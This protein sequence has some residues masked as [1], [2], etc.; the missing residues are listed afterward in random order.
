[1]ARVHLFTSDPTHGEF[2]PLLACLDMKETRVL[3]SD[4]ID[5]L[6]VVG[7][8]IGSHWHHTQVFGLQGGIELSRTSNH[9]RCSEQRNEATSYSH[10]AQ[11]CACPD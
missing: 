10:K 2:A 9:K 4:V 8:T 11:H 6:G 7:G 3:L 5:C 1:M